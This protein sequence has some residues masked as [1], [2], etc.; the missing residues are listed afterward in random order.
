V[1]RVLE[2]GGCLVQPLNI[3]GVPDLLVLHRGRLVLIEVKDGAKVPSKQ[4]L[5]KDQ[6]PW[7]A[8]WAKAPIRIVR[9]VEDALGFLRQVTSEGGQ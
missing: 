3:K 8:L 2:A 1:V 7:H 6:Q 4:R 5:T 9:S